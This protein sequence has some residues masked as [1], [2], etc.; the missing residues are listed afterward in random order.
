MV[1]NRSWKS[2][3]CLRGWKLYSRSL[4]RQ[5]LYNWEQDISYM[6][7]LSGRY[8]SQADVK[9]AA[10]KNM[11]SLSGFILNGEAIM[12]DLDVLVS[13]DDFIKAHQVYQCRISA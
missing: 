12:G 5:L 13:P 11:E 1:S 8:F 2:I 7:E 3:N 6:R 9:M 10:L 4:E